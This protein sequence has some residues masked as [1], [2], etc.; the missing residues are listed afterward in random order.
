MVTIA[1][2]GQICVS[3]CEGS[4]QNSLQTVNK[5]TQHFRFNIQSDVPQND[6]EYGM[7]G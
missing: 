7:D 4:C 3:C 5:F 2:Q 6:H 1:K